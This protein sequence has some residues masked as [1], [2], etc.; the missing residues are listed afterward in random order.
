MVLASSRDIHAL[1]AC[2]PYVLVRRVAGAV[3]STPARG[4]VPLDESSPEVHIERGAFAAV[5]DDLDDAEALWLP[6]VATALSIW[7]TL[8]LELGEAA[9]VTGGHPLSELLGRAAA[10]HGAMPVFQFGGAPLEGTEHVDAADTDAAAAAIRKRAES[11]PG[12]AAV[13]LTGSAATIEALIST[14]PRWGRLHLVGATD[15]FTINFYSDV[16]RRGATITGGLFEPVTLL[17]QPPASTVL[18]T[19]ASRLMARDDVKR[20][21]RASLSTPAPV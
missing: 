8:R 15:R 18:L 10:W 17:N 6:A 19:R 20:M 4:L 9:V 21:T 12:Y 3:P 2:R 11:T 16:H 1:A 13:D 14:L 5:P 7:G